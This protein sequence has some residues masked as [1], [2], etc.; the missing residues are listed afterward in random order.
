[1]ARALG[2]EAMRRELA[3]LRDS[4]RAERR[5][6]VV[7]AMASSMEEWEAEAIEQ[8][9]ALLDWTRDEH[10]GAEVREPDPE[11]MTADQERVF[12]QQMHASRR[13]EG[14]MS[15]EQRAARAYAKAI[16]IYR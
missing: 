4:K 14:S 8:Q 10:S 16:G 12:N 1:M 7:P 9:R 2:T 3:K 11:P 5:V 6:M 13:Q 15:G